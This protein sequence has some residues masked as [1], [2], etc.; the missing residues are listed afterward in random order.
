M[1]IENYL[2]SCLSLP[3]TTVVATD[4]V[5]LLMCDIDLHPLLGGDELSG[6]GMRKVVINSGC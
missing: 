4:S 2:G 1:F 5:L 3:I 6:D